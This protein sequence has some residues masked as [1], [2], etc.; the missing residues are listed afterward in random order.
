[1]VSDITILQITEE[2]IEGFH[3]CLDMVARERKY[4]G[5]L[6]A[7]PLES[8]SE[9][10]R[11]NIDRGI[12]QLVAVADERVIGWCDI[13]PLALEGF[14][15]C[16]RLGMGIESEYRGRGVGRRLLDEAIVRARTFGMERIELEVFASNSNAI[17]LYEKNGFVMEGVK[18]R[19][20]KLDGVWDDNVIMAM[21]FEESREG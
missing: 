15:H 6:Q 1:M 4:L 7:P 9:F 17:A 16:G 10:V 8:T 5:F 21:V 20:R 19:A 18:R 12:P 13:I 11:R 14:Q 3:R 2:H